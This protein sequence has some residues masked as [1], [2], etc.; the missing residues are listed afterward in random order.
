MN[1]QMQ[2]HP[3][4]LSLEWMCNDL[5]TTR[6]TFDKWRVRG[7]GPRMKRF[8]NGSLKCRR[9]WYAAWAGELPDDEYWAGNEF[10][11]RAA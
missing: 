3:T 9:D 8:P 2:D 4:L 7:V 10:T 1:T 6:S 5:G 11:G